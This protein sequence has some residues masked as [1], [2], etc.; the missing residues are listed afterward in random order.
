MVHCNRTRV[1]ALRTESCS[2]LLLKAL[3]VSTDCVHEMLHRVA[4]P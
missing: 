4:S 3:D 1:Y 2:D